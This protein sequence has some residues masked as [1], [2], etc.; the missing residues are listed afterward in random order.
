M[1]YCE[2]QKDEYIATLTSELPVLRAR[3]RISQAEL[4]RGVG[5][6]RQTYS[7]IE[8]QKQKMTWITFMAIIA[9]FS[10][11]EKTRRALIELG[12]ID[13]I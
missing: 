8:T 10:G 11:H 2:D 4:A 5:I 1:I 6:S 13:N 12:L 9:F 7:L 3:A